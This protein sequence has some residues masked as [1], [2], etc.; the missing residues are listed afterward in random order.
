MLW[1]WHDAAV[2]YINPWFN[3]EHPEALGGLFK[4]IYIE[5]VD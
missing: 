3:F 1:E 4:N 5:N 2:L